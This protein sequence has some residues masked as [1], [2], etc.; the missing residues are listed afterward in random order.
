M[1]SIFWGFNDGKKTITQEDFLTILTFL[2]RYIKE[3]LFWIKDDEKKLY[4]DTVVLPMTFFLSSKIN[5]IELVV[6]NTYE[7]F[8][9]ILKY[10]YSKNR[11][12]NYLINMKED[13]LTGALN[14]SLG[15]IIELTI[16]VAYSISKNKNDISDKQSQLKGELKA[17]VVEAFEDKIPEFFIFLGYKAA[18]FLQIDRKWT[19]D[20][21]NSLD[22]GT[23]NWFYFFDTYITTQGCYLDMYD[24]LKNDFL[25]GLK[26]YKTQKDNYKKDLPTIL[27]FI[28]YIRKRNCKA[29][30]Y[31]KIF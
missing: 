25:V 5:E 12:Y 2:Y 1:A 29:D 31:L 24:D 20:I 28:I 6:I 22:K 8:S 11:G 23:E 15:R 19:L 27:Q 26:S 7:L 10:L 9:K 14:S 4:P 17:I 3:D 13:I 21:I 18:V 30:I 16:D